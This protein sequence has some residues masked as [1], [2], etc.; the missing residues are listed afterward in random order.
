MP[1]I[2]QTWEKRWRRG[3]VAGAESPAYQLPPLSSGGA[4]LSEPRSGWPGGN[5]QTVRT[6][7][8]AHGFPMFFT[9]GL[10]R[11][12]LFLKV[13]CNS[14]TKAVIPSRARWPQKVT[15]YTPVPFR[16]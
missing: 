6:G 4:S 16:P 12:C 1:A 5:H 10:V 14:A 7:F 2:G 3:Q 8:P 15:P 9:A 11:H 13:S